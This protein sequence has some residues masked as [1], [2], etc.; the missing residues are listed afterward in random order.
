MN[1]FR[2]YNIL[3]IIILICSACNILCA[4]DN[5]TIE[6]WKYDL[7]ILLRFSDDEVD[8][9]MGM[10]TFNSLKQFAYNHDIADV[11]LR[12]EFGDIE[13]WGFE[14]YLIKYH[15]YWIREL[16]NHSDKL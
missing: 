8:G 11:V 12:G 15:L 14:Q 3:I 16:K 6:Q 2:H 9:I 10:E 4:E 13:G 1:R 7:Q 5:P